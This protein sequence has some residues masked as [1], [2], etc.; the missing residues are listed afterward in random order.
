ML[1]GRCFKILYALWTKSIMHYMLYVISIWGIKLTNKF[2]VL[3]KDKCLTNI[4]I[5][6]NTVSKYKINNI[7]DA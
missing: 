4:A 7:S 5:K 3:Q 6:L 1:S 2:L